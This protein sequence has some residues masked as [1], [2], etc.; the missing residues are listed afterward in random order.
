MALTKSDETVLYAIAS[1][2]SNSVSVGSA[3]DVSS[4]YACLLR[5]R[6]GRGTGTAFTTAPIIRI[7]GTAESGGAQTANQWTVLAQFQTNVG[8]SIGAQAVSG[9]EAAG[10][11]VVT[12]AAGTNFGGGDYVF[13]ENGTLANSEFSRVV[14]IATAD[15]TLEEGLVNAQTGGNCRD[16]AEQFQCS[17]ELLGI[18]RLRVVVDGRATGQAVIVEV[19]GGFCSAL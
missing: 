16:Q 11:T 10:Q 4:Y 2:A 13:F 8:A 7:E 14:S 17:L 19:M 18:N 6:V 1:T 3:L 15:L 12:L 5:I 9:T